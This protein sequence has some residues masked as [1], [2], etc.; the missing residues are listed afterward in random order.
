LK[1]F[2]EFFYFGGGGGG[3]KGERILS[4][5]HAQRGGGA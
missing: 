1:L 4:S 2:C 3:A 5:L